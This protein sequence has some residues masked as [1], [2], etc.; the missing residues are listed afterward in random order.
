MSPNQLA[1]SVATDE[2]DKGGWR[3]PKLWRFLG[4]ALLV[5]VGYMDPG[6]WATDLEGGAR[7]GY[8]LLWVL[9][10]SNLIALL[11]QTLCARLGVVSGFD[12]AQACRAYYPRPAVYGLWLL[13]EVA[14][15]ACD[16]A[17]VIGSAI[18]LN[19]L[20]DIPMV[21]GAAITALDV[22]LIL[23]LQ[24]HGARRLEALILV[25]VLTIAVCF[26]LELTFVQPDWSAVASGLRP[27]LDDATLYIA[28]GILGATVMP[29][30]LYLHSSLVKTRN[31][32]PLRAARVKALRY[33]FVDTAIALN[34]AFLINASILIVAAAVFFTRGVEVG[35]LREAYRLLSPLLGVGLASSLFAIALLCAGQ[36][37]TIT[38]TLAGQIVME[39]FLRL[40]ISPVMRRLLTRGLAVLP[41]IA[42]LAIYGE[43]R[44]IDLLVAT[45]VVLSLQLPFAIVPLIRFTGDA[46]VMSDF[47]SG[48]L[49]KT[50]AWASAAFVVTA[51]CW[52]VAETLLGW[53]H[54][55]AAIAVGLA[56]ALALI[57]V[58][59]VPLQSRIGANSSTC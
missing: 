57:Y 45:Q 47:A 16:L 30:N 3:T 55:P 27:R 39:G 25:A 51:N 28:I 5:G 38:G 13:C 9:V 33:Y 24:Q 18:A 46:R 54:P 36:S 1:G 40:R 8:Q 15:I 53:E 17:E 59:V 50:A 26:A 42:V 37:A 31:I 52:L 58:A 20:F 7:F 43:A 6:N 29:H 22:F 19:L 11:L 49:L 48:F 12:L 35:D 56:Y 41:A 44:T 23:L 2:R 10:L 4:P 14:I 32:A 34:F 21:W